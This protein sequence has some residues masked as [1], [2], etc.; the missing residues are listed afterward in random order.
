LLYL[1]R[2]QKA[3]AL[4]GGL[5]WLL[6]GLGL[7][8]TVL[9][10]L[11]LT[12]G[13]QPPEGHRFPPVPGIEREEV[14]RV[15]GMLLTLGLGW[16]TLGLTWLNRHRQWILRSAKQWLIC[17]LLPVWLVL[18][19]LGLTGL[20]GDYTPALKTL[21]Q[22]PPIAQIL[23][24]NSVDFIVDTAQLNRGERKRYLLLSFYTPHN[25]ERYV[26]WQSV[27]TAWVDPNLVAQRPDGYETL[28]EYY[29]WELVR[30]VR[31]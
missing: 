14:M 19:L 26:Q 2:N 28:A 27:E 16:F 23:P 1:Y 22:A 8:L 12:D 24:A 17:L 5:S 11:G 30:R 18:G 7:G 31:S 6:G 20:W 25:G 15:A 10:I 13:L 4:L 29:G 21:L 9:G 3:T